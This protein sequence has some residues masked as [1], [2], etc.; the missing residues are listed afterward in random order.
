MP[1]IAG[2]FNP[3]VGPTLQVAVVGVD[4]AQSAA[5]AATLHTFNALIDTGASST[6][7]SQKVVTDVGLAP[8]GKVRMA[9]A[10]GMSSVDQ[11][12]FGVGFILPNAQEPTMGGLL[13]KQVSGC[14]FE[15]N[16]AAIDVL[17]GRDVIC[18][19]AFHLSFDGHFTLSF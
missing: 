15:N 17:L 13:V 7:V 18:R 9:S 10:T 12:A 11:F 3:R 19:G 16:E 2:S 14:L 1:C 6:C 5:S 4:L 8:T